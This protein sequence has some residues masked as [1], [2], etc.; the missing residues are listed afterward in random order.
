[1]E[2]SADDALPEELPSSETQPV[3]TS[4]AGEAPAERTAH[5]V[6]GVLRLP[7]AAIMC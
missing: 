5:P 3:E 7:S 1:M 6:P 4:N 2:P